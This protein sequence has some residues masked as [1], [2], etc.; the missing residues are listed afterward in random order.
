MSTKIQRFNSSDVEI[1]HK[2]PV[3]TGFFKMVKYE[4]RHRLFDGGWSRPFQREMFERGHAIAVLPYDPATQEFVLIE[5]FRLGA[6]ATSNTPWLI[7]VIAGIIDE[8]EDADDVC[9][10]EAQEE[11][12]IELTHLTKALSYLSSPG[13]TTERLHIYVAQT[14]ATKATGVHGLEYE[15]EDILVHRVS[16]NDAYEWLQSGR[17]DNAA[18]IIAL[19][20]FFMHKSSLLA[21]WQPTVK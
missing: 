21:Q 18:A 20:W 19:Q 11:A 13:G 15:S 9:H 3:Y 8:G 12:G 5:Q 1:I 16:E 7:E 17:I 2:T 4:L 6:M 14:D 10:R